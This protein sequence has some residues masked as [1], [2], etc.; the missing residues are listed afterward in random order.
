[1]K[2]PNEWLDAVFFLGTRAGHADVGVPRWKGTGFVLS[3]PDE[4]TPG[5]RHL[6]LVTA[7]HNIEGARAEGNLWLRLNTAGGQSV[8]VEADPYGRWRFHDDETVDIAMADPSAIGEF[9]FP[10]A[11][12]TEQIFTAH[13]AEVLD[14]GI[15]SELLTM[16]LF[17][18][19]EGTGHNIPVIRT[20]IVSAMPGELID[21][22]TGHG[23]YS[24]YLAEILSMGGLSGSP[25][26]FHATSGTEMPRTS[27]YLVGVIRSHWD[28]RPPGAL[29]DLPRPEW[30]N[31]GIAA[32]TPAIGIAEMLRGATRP[33]D[34]R[35][36]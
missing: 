28:E 3:H 19:R 35:E 23:P 22:G 20:G 30:L 15:G 36:P 29:Q 9:T 17:G 12:A 5:V 31:R 18:N 16:G 11:L 7:R 21:D 32:V 34:I 1:V 4:L 8:V 6:Y 10:F 13:D 14:F 2:I 25:V 27:F 33:S 24:G 26:F